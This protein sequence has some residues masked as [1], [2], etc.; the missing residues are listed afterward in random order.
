L[1][2]FNSRYFTFKNSRIKPSEVNLS[3]ENLPFLNDEELGD[4]ADRSSGGRLFS[5]EIYSEFRYNDV[6]VGAKLL[7]KL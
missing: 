6:L 5:F 2:L 3:G 1:K 4:K 7:F